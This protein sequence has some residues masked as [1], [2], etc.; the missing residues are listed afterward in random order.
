MC[1]NAE[2]WLYRLEQHVSWPS[3]HAF[4]EDMAFEDKKGVRR[5]EITKDGR[6]TVLAGYAWDGCTPKFCLLDILFGIPD[7]VVDSRTGRPKT[8]YASLIHDV[9]YQFLDDLLPLTRREVDGFFLGLMGVTGFTWRYA[10]YGAV[11]LFGGLFRR[12]AEIVRSRKGKRVP[13]S[14]SV[15]HGAHVLVLEAAHP[16]D[17]ADA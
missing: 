17:P 1:R 10:Y 5:L 13:L 12:G 8:Y 6:I 11:R 3:G 4:P 16:V 14:I 2:R 15:A 7:G 9:L